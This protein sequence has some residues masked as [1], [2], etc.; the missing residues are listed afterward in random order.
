MVKLTCGGNIC[1]NCEIGRPSKAA[2]PISTVRIAITIATIGRRMKKF[3]TAYDGE[4]AS[5]GATN[6]PS[7]IFCKP[8]TI[9]IPSNDFDCARQ[10][11]KSG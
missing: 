8:S 4:R 3:D 7:L 9:A 10:S 1:G 2:L 5:C 6:D 11:S